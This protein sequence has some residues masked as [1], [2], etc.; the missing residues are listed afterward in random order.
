ML[1]IMGQFSCMCWTIWGS[2]AVRGP[3]RPLITGSLCP[4]AQLCVTAFV[5]HVLDVD[6]LLL[7]SCVCIV[8]PLR[9]WALQPQQCADWSITCSGA[10][11]EQQHQRLELIQSAQLLFRLTPLFSGVC[12]EQWTMGNQFWMW[13]IPHIHIY[14]K[15]YLHFCLI[16]S[17]HKLS[18]N[19]SNSLIL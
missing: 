1:C 6:W 10:A 2:G 8:L 13:N 17:N 3:S 12:W 5:L 7:S 18:I 15:P 11:W 19:L 4:Q 16:I 9:C 14:M